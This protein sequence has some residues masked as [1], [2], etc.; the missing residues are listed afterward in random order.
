[1]VFPREDLDVDNLAEFPPVQAG[2]NSGPESGG[3]FAIEDD[4]EVLAAYDTLVKAKR[5]LEREGRSDSMAR[6]P[7]I[8]DTATGKRWVWDGFSSEVVA[9]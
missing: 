9:E 4:G 1:M 2:L 5:H 6:V 8:V 3:R 7:D